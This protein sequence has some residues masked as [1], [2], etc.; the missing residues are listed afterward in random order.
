MTRPH[1]DLT[2]DEAVQ[3]HRERRHA[4]VEKA[5]AETGLTPELLSNRQKRLLA[6]VTDLPAPYASNR[7]D[8][9]PSEYLSRHLTALRTRLDWLVKVEEEHGDAQR[10]AHHNRAERNAL[11]HVL[12]EMAERAGIEVAQAPGPGPGMRYRPEYVDRIDDEF[13]E[14]IGSGYVHAPKREPGVVYHRREDVV[15]LNVPI[16]VWCMVRGYARGMEDA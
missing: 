16:A 10:G 14:A 4:R 7:P 1:N 11:I 5:A 12:G 8:R 6:A 9:S 2:R 13:E 15:P 3:P